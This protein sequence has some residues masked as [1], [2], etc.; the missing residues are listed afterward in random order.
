MK[1]SRKVGRRSRKH[2]SS[3]VSRRRLRNK[4]RKHTKTQKG[5]KY[6]KRGRG[7]KR[8]RTYKHGKRFHRG[9]MYSF[10][11]SGDT[12]L[13]P[14]TGKIT[15]LRYNKIKQDE[16]SERVDN[17]KITIKYDNDNKITAIFTREGADRPLSFTFGPISS[18]GVKTLIENVFNNQYK[19]ENSTEI[20]DEQDV[21][22]TLTNTNDILTHINKYIHQNRTPP[23]TMK[24]VATAFSRVQ[25]RLNIPADGSASNDD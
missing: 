1:V 13:D 19:I 20:L 25:K 5:G 16:P 7:H 9:G 3:S 22:Y 11:R 17:F 18:D 8:A 21:T 6:V 2:T 10:F 14:Q 15:N 24:D 12:T 4:N 23:A